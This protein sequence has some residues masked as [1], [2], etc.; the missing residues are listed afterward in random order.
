M[1]IPYNPASKA[2][3][4][5]PVK[6]EA[7]YFQPETV[8]AILD[9]AD[10]EPMKYRVFVYLTGPGRP[11]FVFFASMWITSLQ[12]AGTLEVHTLTRL[13]RTRILPSREEISPLKPRP[14]P[15]HSHSAKIAG[16]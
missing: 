8:Y 2:T 7:N 5:R 14:N 6:P 4:P 16:A 15:P 12:F 9:A 1:L 13:Y 3:P 10:T 11:A